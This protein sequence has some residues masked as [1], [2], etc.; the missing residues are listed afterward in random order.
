MHIWLTLLL[1]QCS[2]PADYLD[3][4]GPQK[5]KDTLICDLFPEN[6]YWACEMLFSVVTI[7]TKH[8]SVCNFYLAIKWVSLYF[9]VK[10]PSYANVRA[11]KL[12]ATCVYNIY[13]QLFPY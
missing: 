11:Q 3:L 12:A 13:L 1:T 5:G 10:F 8:F 6:S 7:L 9:S 4:R 2:W